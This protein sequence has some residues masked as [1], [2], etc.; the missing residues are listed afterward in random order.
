MVVWSTIFFPLVNYP[1]KNG[2]SIYYSIA[3]IM[4]IWNNPWCSVNYYGVAIFI[5]IWRMEAP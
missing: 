2:V 5:N 1:C 3:R 4:I